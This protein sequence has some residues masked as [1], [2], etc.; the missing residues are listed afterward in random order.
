MRPEPGSPVRADTD[1][2]ALV[3]RLQKLRKLLPAFAQETAAA[4]REA[5]RL[6][7]QNT[8]LQTRLAELEAGPRQHDTTSIQPRSYH[9]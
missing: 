8:K 6:R 9:P 5:A 7:L 2:A 3:D 4:R 1:A